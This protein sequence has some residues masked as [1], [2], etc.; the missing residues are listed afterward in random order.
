MF[1]DKD[2]ILIY[3]N[4]IKH[5]WSKAVTSKEE[6]AIWSYKETPDYLS[7]KKIIKEKVIS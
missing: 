4:L 7:Q 2:R 1:K 5:Y 3:I 6:Y